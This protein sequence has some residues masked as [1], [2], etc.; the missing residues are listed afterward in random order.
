MKYRLLLSGILAALLTISCPRAQAGPFRGLWVNAWE[1]GIKTPEQVDRLV[2]TAREGGITA[3]LVQVHKRADAYYQSDLVPRATDIA[4]GFDPLADI[5]E[6]AHAAGIEVHA[7][8]VAL[9]AHSAVPGM[10]PAPNALVTLHPDWITFSSAGRRMGN[11]QAEGLYLDPGLP[12]VQDHVVAVAR[13]IVERYPVDGIN[14]DYIRYPGVRFGYHPKAVWRFK[15][16][17][18]KSILRHREAWAQWRR[19]Q[20]SRL[21]SRIREA[22]KS[23]RPEVQV[24][25]DVWADIAQARNNRLQ[26]WERWLRAGWVDFV[27]PM[28]YTQSRTLFAS[29]SARIFKRNG[30]RRVYMGI[31]EGTYTL[32]MADQVAQLGGE[33]LVFYHYGGLSQ[34]FWEG[35]RRRYVRDSLSQLAPGG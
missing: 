6:K 30:S 20:V 17:T 8:V 27:A 3:L 11:G 16:E 2:A 13:E 15:R 12:E 1:D 23:V 18:G 19:D 7:W 21:V 29:R 4:E 5:L 32:D 35:A 33:G 26:D 9:L 31:I 10:K 25:A 28:N 34:R 24:S 14:L 22:V